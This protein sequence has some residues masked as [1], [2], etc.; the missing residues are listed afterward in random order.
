MK[1]QYTSFFR[2]LNILGSG[3]RAALKRCAGTMLANAD[4]KAITVFY[5]CLPAFVSESQ[6]DRW[7]AAG[8][9]SCLWDAGAEEGI[10]FEVRLGQLLRAGALSDSTAHRIETLLDTDWDSDGYML[11]KLARLVKMVRQK[12]SAPLDLGA[13]LDD[14]IYWNSDSQ[15]VQRKWARAIFAGADD[16]NLKGE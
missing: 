5:R 12:D 16:A 8:C 11:S 9:L 13:L 10:P 14:L 4:G 2:Q 6:A 7:F 3:D 1:E 15:Y